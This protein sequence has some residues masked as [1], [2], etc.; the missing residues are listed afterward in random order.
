[1]YKTSEAWTI[2]ENSE[3]SILSVKCSKS[4]KVCSLQTDNQIQSQNRTQEDEKSRCRS[5]E[6]VSDAL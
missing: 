4:C 2:Y 3:Y 5:V 1:M 6:R